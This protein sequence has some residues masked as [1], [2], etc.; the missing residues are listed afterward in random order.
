VI[1]SAFSSSNVDYLI[2]S[3]QDF[4]TADA[5]LV[6]MADI[7]ANLAV[8]RAATSMQQSAEWGNLAVHP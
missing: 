5:G 7:M 6:D 4:L 8:K 2:K 1:D 3:A